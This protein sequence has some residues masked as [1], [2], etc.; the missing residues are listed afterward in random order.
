MFG[1]TAINGFTLITD[2]FMVNKNITLKKF[3]KI[4]LEV[5]FYYLLFY[6]IFLK[7]GYEPFSVKGLVKIVFN[8]CYEAGE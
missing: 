4:Y 7:S 3:L 8:I 2:Y 1:K 5:K 6:L